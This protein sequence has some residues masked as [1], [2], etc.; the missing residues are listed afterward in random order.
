[1]AGR[2]HDAPQGHLRR[3]WACCANAS[4]GWRDGIAAAEVTERRAGRTRLQ[5]AQAVDC[6]D[7]LPNDLLAKLDR[8]LMAHGVEGRTPFLDPLVADLAF[9][10]PDRL[11]VREGKGKWLLRRWLD[12]TLPEAGAFAPKRGFTVPVAQ[13]IA[14]E[15]ARL[16]PL[17]AAQPGVAEIA[18]PAACTSCSATRASTPASPP[19]HLLFY[20]LWHRRHILRPA[21]GRRCVSLSGRNALDWDPWTTHR[22]DRKNRRATRTRLVI[23]QPDDW[24]VHL[25]D[26][27]MLRPCV[28]YTARQFARAIVMPNLVPPVTTRR[29]RD[30]LSRRA[31][32]RRCRPTPASRR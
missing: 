8:C 24:H 28:P 5:A 19:G 2:A 27:A 18:D 9:R 17:V 21:A 7:W 4:V 25:R 6:A 26:G 23:R 15:G 20:A 29:G 3:A 31:S 1:M 14:A 13:W 30:R 11:K 16:G 32:S 12:R 10:L 22:T